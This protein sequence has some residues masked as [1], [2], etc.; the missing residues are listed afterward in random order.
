M[1][2]I[3][4]LSI[5]PIND[6]YQSL[7]HELIYSAAGTQSTTRGTTLTLIGKNLQ[8][9][10][11][12]HLPIIT[13]RRI[14]YPLA[15]CELYC[16]LNAFSTKEQFN[17]NYVKFWDKEFASAGIDDLGEYRYGKAWKCWQGV[18]QIQQAI[19]LLKN[20]KHTRSAFILSQIKPIY[21]DCLSLPCIT[22]MYINIINNTLY[23]TVIQRS[24]DVFAGL[25]Y[26]IVEYSVL[27][28]LFANELN[29][30]NVILDYHLVNCH[31]YL[32]HY[33]QAKKILKLAPYHYPFYVCNDKINDFHYSHTKVNE[34]QCHPEIKI[35]LNSKQK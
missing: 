2:Q 3:I 27:A 35:T 32:D 18:N 14:K 17:S 20:N 9:D 13:T 5:L 29:V 8:F 4:D 23:L 25:P 15:F 19:S 7:L 30:Q 28:K 1:T 21:S 12:D 6:W 34:F 11:T 10:V 22:S 33:Q 24:A 26:D 31:L 16:F